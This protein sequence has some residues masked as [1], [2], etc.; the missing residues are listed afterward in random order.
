MNITGF[1]RSVSINTSNLENGV[2]VVT[3]ID[4]NNNMQ[5]TRIVKR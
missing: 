1:E 3:F 4:A 5:S 2:Y